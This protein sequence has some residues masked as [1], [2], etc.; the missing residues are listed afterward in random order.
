MEKINADSITLEAV[1]EKVNELIDF[2][3]NYYKSKI[4]E[5]ESEM[6]RLKLDAAMSCYN[7]SA[8]FPRK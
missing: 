1:A 2:V 4:A 5:N 8:L 6:I 3:N 7:P